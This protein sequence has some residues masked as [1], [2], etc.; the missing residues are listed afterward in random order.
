MKKFFT[1]SSVLAVLLLGSGCGGGGGSNNSS[2]TEDSSVGSNSNPSSV[3]SKRGY[4]V[5]S[6]VSGVDFNCV[7]ENNNSSVPATSGVTDSKGSFVFNDNQICKFSIGSVVLREQKT[8]DLPDNGIVFEDN[9]DVAR[10]LQTLDKDGYS[11]NGIEIDSNV[12]KVIET[13]N[14]M[15]DGS[16]PATDEDLANLVIALQE[17]IADYNGTMITEEEAK[18]HIDETKA[19]V[20][21]MNG[22]MGDD[23]DSD[24]PESLHTN[25]DSNVNEAHDDRNINRVQDSIEDNKTASMDRVV[26]SE[27][28]NSAQDGTHVEGEGSLENNGSVNQ[29]NR[30]GTNSTQTTQA[31]QTSTHEGNSDNSSD[32]SNFSYGRR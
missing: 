16:I 28:S 21:S 24:S 2:S 1:F 4:Y 7:N 26:H 29:P 25:I 3:V 20:E 18:A 31:T 8:A 27:N 12:A 10:F 9:L 17:K 22:V 11:D 15:P 32:R 19:I 13:M 14:L 30:E 6:A 5:D 23:I